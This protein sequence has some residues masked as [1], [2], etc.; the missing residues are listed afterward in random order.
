MAPDAA[1][2][3]GYTSK[4]GTSMATPLM[5][6]IAALMVEANPDIT[7]DEVKA[8]ISVDSI[9]RDLQLLDDPGFNDCSIMESR[10]DNEFGFGQADP[11][12]F[13][14]SAGSID[15][16]LN[17][18]MDIK[19]LQHVGNE[20]SIS[21]I[22]SGGSSGVGFVQIKVGGGDWQ[23][24]TDLSSSGD[25]SSWNLKLKPHT[26]SGNSTIY[27]RLVISDDQMSPV[28]ARRVILIDGK[29]VSSEDISGDMTLGFYALMISFIAIVSFLGWTTYMT[30]NKR[31]KDKQL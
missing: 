8:I 25:W 29:N 3:D 5:A 21:G 23:Q 14:Q 24:A 4:S 7:H 17:I 16:T 31:I 1:T 15:S 11:L 19:N 10:P 12:Q 6:G 30:R 18:T 26:E 2:T 13:V 22:S 9:E 20:S 27:S 28:D